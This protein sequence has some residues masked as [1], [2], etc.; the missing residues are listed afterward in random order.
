VHFTRIALYYFY[1]VDVVAKVEN[2]IAG[3]TRPDKKRVE[4]C[5]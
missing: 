4:L 1:P 5:D 2:A 3:G